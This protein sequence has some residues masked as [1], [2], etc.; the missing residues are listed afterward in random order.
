MAAT[1]GGV[2]V[3]VEHRAGTRLSCVQ[4][5][6]PICPKCLVR[7]PV[8]LKCISCGG[9]VPPAGDPP[10]PRRR[11]R[12]LAAAAAVATLVALALA[13]ALPG[14]L[15]EDD[16]ASDPDAVGFVPDPSG[17]ARQAAV[18][19]EARDGDFAFVVSGVDCGAREV[20]TNAG[21]SRPAQGQYCVV[22]FDVRNVGRSPA[23]FHARSQLL[24]DTADRRFAPDAIATLAHPGNAGRDVLEPV[25]NPGNHLTGVLVFDVPEGVRLRAAALRHGPA[26]PGATVFLAPA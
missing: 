8:G 19:E 14:L 12:A 6:A 10:A 9:P 22:A 26:G 21:G 4:C 20:A 18:G 23:T 17:P 11:N 5:R 16:P 3:C 1:S 25:I 2:P 13:V 15:A 7:T 24:V